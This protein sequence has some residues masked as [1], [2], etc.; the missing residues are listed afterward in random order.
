VNGRG[1]IE[2]GGVRH[3]VNL[4]VEDD[5]SRADLAG[6]LAGELVRREGARFLLGPYGSDATT[7]VA[8]VAERLGVPHVASNGAALAIYGQGHR[9]TFGV[10]SPSDRYMTTV[11]D[12]AAT[13]RP[14]PRTIAMLAADDSFSLEVAASVR[15]QAPARGFEVVLDE[16]YPA[17]STATTG[18]V[19]RAAALAPDV[20]LNS[21][22][23]A[24]AVAIHRAARTLGL[25]A[26]IFA[27]SVGPSTP[28]FVAE[29]GPDADYVLVG[30][31]W[32]PQV[33]YRPQL[34]V[35]T[36]EYVAAYK[37]TF[38][39]LADP[40]YQTADA[41]AAALALERAIEQAGSTRRE[42][43]RDA[44]ARLDVLTFY[45]RLR[46]DARGANVFKPMVVEQIQRSRRH[47]VYPA[48]VADA[49]VAYPTPPWS[50]RT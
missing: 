41:T 24:E 27:Y 50:R 32:S 21:G 44:L 28:D 14:R 33:R 26:R 42:A 37:R 2:V 36:P 19:A 46:F 8:A 35:T 9:Y 15:A 16:R 12:L 30:S 11:L 17:G 48:D 23:L 31:Q 20:L 29:L 34:Y 47:T 39:T 43:V 6:A 1:G 38:R 13:L 40:A 49:R 25:D 18:L 45:G 4:V 7:A 3:R 22:H 10:L 5:Q